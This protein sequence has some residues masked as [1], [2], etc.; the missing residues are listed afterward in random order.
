MFAR[1]MDTIPVYIEKVMERIKEKE[2]HGTVDGSKFINEILISLRLSKQDCKDKALE[3]LEEH[4]VINVSKGRF[5]KLKV[6][7]NDEV[8]H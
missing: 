7:I 5:N 2:M 1:P 6:T 3:E 8:T 4:G